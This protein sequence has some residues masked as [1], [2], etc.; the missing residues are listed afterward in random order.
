MQLIRPYR[1]AWE[2]DTAVELEERREATEV[3]KAVT[4]TFTPGSSKAS[5][6]SATPRGRTMSRA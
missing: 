1:Q 5:L 2:Q 6:A 3:E 4:T